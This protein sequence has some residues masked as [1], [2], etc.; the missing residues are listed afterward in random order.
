MLTLMVILTLAVIGIVMGIIAA[1]AFLAIGGVAMAIVPL[2]IDIW[3]VVIVLKW[4]F[5][6]KKSKKIIIYD[7]GYKEKV[8]AE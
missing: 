7:E 6:K 4:L 2:L 1:I 8:D 3:I 5:R